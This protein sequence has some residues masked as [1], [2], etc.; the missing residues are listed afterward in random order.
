MGGKRK[1]DGGT[2]QRGWGAW[3][4]NREGRDSKSRTGG[5]AMDGRNIKRGGELK[6]GGEWREKTTGSV[7]G[8]VE[9]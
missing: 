9:G 7:V 5:P 3:N 2:R 6:R 4:N 8:F 1:M